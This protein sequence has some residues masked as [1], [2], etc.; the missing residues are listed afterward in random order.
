[1]KNNIYIRQATEADCAML[2]KVIETVIQ[3]IP[4]YND[5]AKESEIAKFREERLITKVAADKYAVILA[6]INDKIVGFCLNRFDDNL[7]WLEWYGILEAHRG[8]GI[9]NLLLKELSKTI[10]IR[11]CHKIWCDC[12]TSNEAS[13][14][15]LTNHGFRQLLTI[16]NHWYKQDFILWEKEVAPV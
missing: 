1:M 13:I 4:Y 14:H 7:I 2:S 3:G 10:S 15:I 11:Q 5:L 12:R 16:A 6:T 8:K 9:S